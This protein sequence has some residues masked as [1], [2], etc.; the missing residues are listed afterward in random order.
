MRDEPDAGESDPGP[1]AV[2]LVPATGSGVEW[3]HRL[4]ES[5]DLP[6]AD[7]NGP[8]SDDGPALY[9]VRSEAG[10]VGCIG[11]ERYGEH[12]L[13]RSAVV[14]EGYRGEG[15]G[16][17][18]VRALETEAR[19]AGIETLYLLTTTAPDFFAGLGYERVE[20]STVPEPVRGSAEFSEL[21]PDSA[22]VMRREP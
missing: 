7:L 11:V 8:Q 18:A 15:Y 16:R 5:A 4:L 17:A 14:R 12:G 1:P 19:D 10:R 2:D 3:V 9:V 6:V 21:C 13:L 20:R 22:V